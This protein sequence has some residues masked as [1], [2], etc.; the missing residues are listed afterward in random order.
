M[1]KSFKA[2]FESRMQYCYDVSLPGV[3]AP[4]TQLLRWLASEAAEGC[5]YVISS[6]DCDSIISLEIKNINLVNNNIFGEYI[7]MIETIQTQAIHARGGISEEDEEYCDDLTIEDLKTLEK[8]EAFEWDDVVKLAITSGVEVPADHGHVRTV[9]DF[10]NKVIPGVYKFEA[11]GLEPW[12]IEFNAGE[13]L[14]SYATNKLRR[15]K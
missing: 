7:N 12:D 3:K 6:S 2:F 13:V 8:G 5:D 9:M 4:V 1:M 15:V 11:R 14:P 10:V